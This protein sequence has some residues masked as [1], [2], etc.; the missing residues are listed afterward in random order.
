MGS[1]TVF[2]DNIN[3]C[4]GY[5]AIY[6]PAHLAIQNGLLVNNIVIRD[7]DIYSTLLPIDMLELCTPKR[8]SSLRGQS[9]VGCSLSGISTWFPR[10]LCC[11]VANATCEKFCSGI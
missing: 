7:D 4:A 6:K 5:F 1:L 2:Y 10:H 9:T 8:W 11:G 3:L